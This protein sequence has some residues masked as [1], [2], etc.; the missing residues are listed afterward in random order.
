[1]S[2]TA[3]MQQLEAHQVPLHKIF[4]SDYDFRIPDYQRPYAW[5]R[6]QATQLLEDLVEALDRGGDEPYFLGSIVLV[7]HKGV[8]DAE[9][10]DGQQRLTTLTILLAVLRARAAGGGDAGGLGRRRAGGAGR[11]GDGRR[12]G[13]RRPGVDGTGGVPRPA[14]GPARGRSGRLLALAVAPDLLDVAGAH[15][16]RADELI[17]PGRTAAELR[18][19]D[20]KADSDRP[21]LP[22]ARL[23]QLAAALSDGD[24]GGLRP[25]RAVRPRP[26]PGGRAPAGPGR[27]HRGAA[28]RRPG[29]PRPGARP[30]PAAAWAARPAPAGRAG[31]RGRT[32][33]ALRRAAARLPRA[34]GGP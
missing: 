2:R 30:L 23:V 19:A 8:S 14:A 25:G 20:R 33:P 28:D 7:K 9:V 5:E 34:H 26:G 18:A 11:G 1:M 12:A 15:G 6:E 10:I 3:G 13:R 24:R 32:H 27:C 21:P 22:D 4:C 29:D 31:Q 16:Q 17:A